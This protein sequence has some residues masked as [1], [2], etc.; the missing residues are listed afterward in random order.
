MKITDLYFGIM[1]PNFNTGELEQE[2][3]FA[4]YRILWSIA[5][6]V[7]K[8]DKLHYANDDP[9]FWCFGEVCGRCEYEMLVGDFPHG[10]KLEKHDIYTLYVKPNAELLMSMV[11]SVNKNSAISW[12]RQNNKRRKNDNR[13]SQKSN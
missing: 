4:N 6:Y 11:D 13:R 7:A 5:T 8:K 3:L 10:N 2:N 1:R 12:L 9:L